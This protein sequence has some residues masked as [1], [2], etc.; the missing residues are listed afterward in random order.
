MVSVQGAGQSV[1]GV[2]QGRVSVLLW[3]RVRVRASLWMR[4]GV[5]VKGDVAAGV[6]TSERR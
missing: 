5:R 2:G 3:V 6:N 1:H 4:V